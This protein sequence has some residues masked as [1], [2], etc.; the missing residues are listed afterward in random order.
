MGISPYLHTEA[1]ENETLF[2]Y[3]FLYSRSSGSGFWKA[4]R[5]HKRELRGGCVCTIVNLMCVL[6]IKK[7]WLH[8]GGGSFQVSRRVSI[9]REP[10]LIYYLF[11]N[12]STLW[13]VYFSALKVSVKSTTHIWWCIILI[14]KKRPR[15]AES[16]EQPSKEQDLYFLSTPLVLAVTLLFLPVWTNKYYVI[17]Y[18]GCSFRVNGTKHL[19]NAS[20]KNF[21]A[22]MP[23]EKGPKRALWPQN[24]I[25]NVFTRNFKDEY[26]G[27]IDVKSL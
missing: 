5:V 8:G 11:I 1:E 4:T 26:L 20:W 12:R 13:K 9:S 21:S 27:K 2:F 17:L 25:E 3:P 14:F 6:F 23:V 24:I 16:R 15:V 7:G 22:T 19:T 18:T 10:N